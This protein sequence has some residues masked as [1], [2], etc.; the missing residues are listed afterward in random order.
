LAEHDEWGVVGGGAE[1][2]AADEVDAAVAP[3]RVSQPS[4]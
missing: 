2:E 4:W 1:V 3:G